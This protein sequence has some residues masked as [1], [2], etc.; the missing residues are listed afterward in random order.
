[1]DTS[2]VIVIN[3]KAGAKKYGRAKWAQITDAV[4][5]LVEADKARGVVTQVV[6]IDSRPQMEFFGGKP[7]T[8]ASSA[9]QTKRAIDAIF[10]AVHPHYILLLGGPDLIPHVKLRNPIA[11]G[12][13]IRVPSDLPY[14]CNE[15]YSLDIE[16]Y[17]GPTRVLGRLP[18]VTGK[19]DPSYLIG[20]L[21]TASTWKPRPKNS[22][23]K[24][25]ALT[26]EVWKGS[27]RKSVRKLFKS[28]KKLNLIPPDAVPWSKSELAARVHF[29]NCHGADFDHRFFG[30]GNGDFPIAHSSDLLAGVQEGTVVAAECCF[31]MQLYKPTSTVPMGLCNRYL[32][33]GAYAF[34][35]SSNIAYGPAEGNGLADLICIFFIRSLQSGAS[36]GRAMLEAHQQFIS[37]EDPV[38]P[39]AL[40]TLAQFNLLG[41]PSIHPISKPKIRSIPAE[42]K[43]F[44]SKATSGLPKSLAEGASLLEIAARS[45]RRQELLSRGLEFSDSV[46][47]ASTASRKAV[48][49]HLKQEMVEY[50]KKHELGTITNLSAF[51]V[52]PSDKPSPKSKSARA[53]KHSPL[54]SFIVALVADAASET[55]TK[56]SSGR[57]QA[58]K[59][60]HQTFVGSKTARR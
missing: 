45:N 23:K 34:I 6:Q 43:S 50:A 53:M 31:G 5:L 47:T 2:K 8:K 16:T 28:T 48:H 9:Q 18:D 40:K 13:D 15:R 25:F 36:T 1:M 49:G 19:Q 42:E 33:M 51:N 44:F 22:F 4:S 57:W 55:E 32:E 60:Y 12:E 37:G 35:G 24:Y 29:I 54:G 30:E 11:D 17:K 52:E 10:D 21:K 59:D 20:L 56:E 46:L 41:D 38:G 14:A 3:H 27:T 58:C 7:V 26:A 39:H